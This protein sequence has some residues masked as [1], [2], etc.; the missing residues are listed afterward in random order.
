[1]SWLYFGILFLF[2]LLGP[3]EPE[4][5]PKLVCPFHEVETF[6]WNDSNK[7]HKNLVTRLHSSNDKSLVPACLTS[8]SKKPICPLLTNNVIVAA[9]NVKTDTLSKVPTPAIPWEADDNLTIVS[10]TWEKRHILEAYE[11]KIGSGYLDSIVTSKQGKL[12]STTLLSHS[13]C[14]RPSK[15]KFY[16]V[17][18]LELH[19]VI[20]TILK[21]FW[22]EF[23][24][25]DLHN[26][27]LLCKDFASLV[28]KITRWLMVDFSLLPK[29]RY[30]YEQ[31]EWV[32]P[33][34]IEMANA[35]MVHFGLDPGK[36]VQWMGG[37]YT[38]Y[39]C[40]V[41]KTLAAVCLYITAKDYNHIEWILLGGCPAELMFT[42]PLDNKLKMI[43]Q[44]NLKS[45][46]DNPNL[47]GKAMNKEDQYSHLMPIN[48]DIC[49]VSAYHRHT[50]QTVVMKLG[51]NDWL[52]RDGTTIHLAL[53]IVMNQATPV[54]RGAPVTFDHIGIQSYIDIYNKCISHPNDVILLGMAGIK[55]CFCFPRIHPN[56]TG[57]F[58]FMAD[59][60]NNLATAMVFG[61]T[62]SASSWEPFW[63]A[64]EALSVAYA[65]HPDLVITNKPFNMISWAKH[66]PTVKIIPA[67]PCSISKETL[68]A[69]G[70]RA[71]LPARIYVDDAL[72]L[73]LSKCHMELVLAALI[74]AIFVIMGKP[75]RT[76]R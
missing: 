59:G 76:V 54:T 44:G 22:A 2:W 20:A 29:P 1:M 48:D 7:I 31:Q 52:V 55:E 4:L 32:N 71:K 13:T 53:D 42:E 43:R 37:E 18:V 56:L 68:E 58:G 39:N 49:H 5:P 16:W 33:N 26:L 8:E 14:M 61:S 70:N 50:I 51:K 23:M 38:G 64:I 72:M 60:Y 45:F 74:K 30:N 67:I 11:K 25:Q 28:P 10:G 27:C 21:K 3:D 46:N 47:I 24:V 73:A 35:A 66:D 34:C 40:D 75:D 36:F 19:S 69:H 17:D 15:D 62:T 12:V 9:M 65:D 41:Q 57:A 6:D 63:Q